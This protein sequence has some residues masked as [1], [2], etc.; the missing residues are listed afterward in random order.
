MC[1]K[2]PPFKLY[3]LVGFSIFRIVQLSLLI[4]KHFRHLIKKVHAIG[5]HSHSLSPSPNLVCT[6]DEAVVPKLCFIPGP[7]SSRAE[8]K[9]LQPS[10]VLSLFG[11]IS[12]LGSR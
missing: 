1:Y 12:F 6:C 9:A 5:S 10:P 3:D 7:R 4:L 8:E 2:I 11:V